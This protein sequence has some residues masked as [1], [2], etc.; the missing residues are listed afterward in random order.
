[1]TK[2]IKSKYNLPKSLRDLKPLVKWAGGKEKEL[3]HIVPL[4]PS[5]YE[6]Y[7]EPFIGGG[8]VFFKTVE[9]K[10]SFLNDRS[11]ELIS[12]YKMIQNQNTVFLSHLENINESWFSLEEIVNS[13]RISFIENYKLFS[14]SVIDE[15]QIKNLFF[16]FIETHVD[17]FRKIDKLQI[18]FD[19]FIKEIEKSI[20]NKVKRMK[21][22]EHIKHI[23]HDQD[24]Y[25]NILGAIKSAYYMYIRRVY[26]KHQKYNISKE[27]Y[28][29]IFF[30]IRNYCYS[31]M[32]RYNKSGEFNVPYGGIGYN[33]KS[34]CSKISY[35]KNKELLEQ[36]DNTVIENLDFEVFLKK[37]CP[38]SK[39]FIFIDPPYD[40]EFSTYAKNIFD[41]EDQ[42]RLSN[43]LIKECKAKWM[44]VIKNTDFIKKL[45]DFPGINIMS[46]DKKYLVSFMNR[47]NKNVQHLIIT[48]YIPNRN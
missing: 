39:D 48:N 15:N 26:N 20:F 43:Y 8:A 12:L 21:K 1:M 11:T 22:I 9:N 23:L 36:L 35:F 2:N 27:L 14:K 41:R 44:L 25:D 32:F 17:T 28:T 29:A 46:F 5:N 16:D 47:N 18:D 38:K 3:K 10:P 30:F 13:N 6:K 19:F 34:L 45:Y 24:V 37:H 42:I 33:N 31:G 4:I 40:T 7:Y